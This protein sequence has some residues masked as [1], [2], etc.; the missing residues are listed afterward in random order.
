MPLTRPRSPPPT[1]P[2]TPATPLPT[3]RRRSPTR[4]AMSPMTPRP[5]PPRKKPSIEPYRQ[6][7][8]G[9]ALQEKPR[10]GCGFTAF[11]SP[12]FLLIPW[13]TARKP[14]RPRVGCAGVAPWM[15]RAQG[16]IHGAPARPTRAAHP[17]VSAPTTRGTAVGHCL[18][19]A[20]AS[21]AVSPGRQRPEC[22]PVLSFQPAAH[23]RLGDRAA[24]TQQQRCLQQ[25]RSALAE[26]SRL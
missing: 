21:I 14:S 25:Q 26:Q 4:R 13:W 18:R 1:R 3:P 11:R 22:Q 7:S 20:R 24:R 16:R 15:A 8:T 10:H 9:S 2:R 12:L 23:E 19:R 17:S 6:P 5:T